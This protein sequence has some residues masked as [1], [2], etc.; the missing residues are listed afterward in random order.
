LGEW[1]LFSSQPTLKAAF[2][3]IPIRFFWLRC[4]LRSDTALPWAAIIKVIFFA[5]CSILCLMGAASA[6]ASRDSGGPQFSGHPG[7]HHTSIE[8]AKVRQAA[9]SAR[10]RV[11]SATATAKDKRAASAA[12]ASRG[13][14]AISS[15]RAEQIQSARIR[16][17]RLDGEASGVWDQR[18]KDAMIRYQAEN[19]WQ[20]KITPDSRALIKLGLGPRHEG[21]LNP[22]S[23]ALASPHELGAEREIPGER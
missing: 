6:E 11:R 17:H 4:Y 18:T 14:Q 7:R 20:T 3:G 21:L 19:G 15:E 13:Q 12:R 8:F 16:E 5:G 22:D 10:N 2:A 23:A 1:V 9:T